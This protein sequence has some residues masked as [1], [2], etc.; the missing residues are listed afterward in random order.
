MLKNLN[1]NN[2]VNKFITRSKKI[3]LYIIYNFFSYKN[4]IKNIETALGIKKKINLITFQ[5]DKAS[6]VNFYLSSFLKN[7]FK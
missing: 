3:G 6:L 5:M 4:K 1:N 7:S 2:N